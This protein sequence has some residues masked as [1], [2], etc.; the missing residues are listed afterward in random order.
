MLKNSFFKQLFEEDF[1]E[2]IKDLVEIIFK[3]MVNMGNL[4]FYIE[5]CR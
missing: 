5:I 1:D 4:E 3:K 2:G